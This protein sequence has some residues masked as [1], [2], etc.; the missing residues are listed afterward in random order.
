MV[1]F[2]QDLLHEFCK[3]VVFDDRFHPVECFQIDNY[4]L[5]LVSAIRDIFPGYRSHD[6]IVPMFM[7]ESIKEIPSGPGR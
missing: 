6:C 3:P 5:L 1:S 7:R 2:L 4:R